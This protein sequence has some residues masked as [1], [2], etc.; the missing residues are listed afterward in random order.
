MSLS[1]DGVWKA[2]V[3]ATTVWADGI[4]REGAPVTPP[5]TVVIAGAGHPGKHLRH[6]GKKRYETLAKNSID[7]LLDKSLVE[8]YNELTGV[9]ESIETKQEAVEIV[10]PYVKKKTKSKIPSARAIN[11]RAVKD[12]EESASRLMVLWYEKIGR[13]RDEQLRKHRIAEDEEI[14]LLAAILM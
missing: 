10:A 8:I 12:D 1:I 3:W 14:V 9:E 6:K 4:W 2:G 13:L 5:V 7:E 11:F